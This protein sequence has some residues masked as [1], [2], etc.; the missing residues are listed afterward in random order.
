MVLRDYQI[1]IKNEGIEV[2]NKYNVLYLAL[3][4]R[5]GKTLTALHICIQFNNV[6]F[7]T[8]KKAIKSIESDYMN[9][10]LSFNL[11]V[12][13]YESVHKVNGYFDAIV[14]DESHAIGQYPKANNRC[15]ALKLL[16]TNKPI[17]YLSATPCPESWSQLYHQFW[18]S[19]FS[20]FRQWPNFYKWAGQFVNIQKKHIYNREINDYTDADKTKIWP[21]IKHLFITQ[22]QEAS[23]FK[24]EVNEQVLTVPLPE[25][26]KVAI[27]NV[28]KN[29][30]H[31]DGDHVILADT[32]VKVMQKVHQLS[33]GTVI[34]ESENYI[35]LSDFKARYLMEW[36]KGK[37]LAIFYKFKSEFTMLK[38]Y[39]TNWTDEAS[40]FQ[41]EKDSTFLGQFVSAREGIRLDNADAIVFFNIDFSYLSYEQARNRI[42]SF[43]RSNNATLYWLF[44]DKGIER[45][46]YKAVM[47]KQDYT[48][49]IYQNDRISISSE[50]A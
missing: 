32:A 34:T 46:I 44:S 9:S 48:L 49:K 28:M 31:Y 2:L 50:L 26:I 11:T 35:I 36:G 47:D 25:N 40:T 30:V 4:T 1:R 5:T 12:I 33:S 29:N 43:E 39:F 13:N 14:C 45:K 17:I 20:P 18:I 6:L 24:V 41:T 19:S 10:G 37:K 38:N 16:A 3:Q 23:G 27:K 22:T 8:K 7:V 15:K 21:I 42:A